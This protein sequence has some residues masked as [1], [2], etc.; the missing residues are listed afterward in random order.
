MLFQKVARAVTGIIFRS[1]Y[2]IVFQGVEQVP[3]KGGFLVCC[4]HRTT[5]DPIFLAQKVKCNLRFMAKAELFENPFFSFIIRH[6]GAFPVQRGKGDMTAIQT[7]KAAL[8]Q[9]DS[10]IMFP[11]GTRSKD[12][13]LLKIKSGAVMIAGQTGADILPMVICFEGKLHF[14]SKIVV[15]YGAVIP[16]GELGVSAGAPN[17]SELR[18]ANKLLQN[19]LQE[20]LDEA[21]ASL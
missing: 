17:P 4:N 12:G 7:A 18:S 6:L 5:L 13:K 10:L 21:N 9:G 2:H 14:R 19:R 11:E 20:L 1:Y 15:R 16:N 8:T 3:K